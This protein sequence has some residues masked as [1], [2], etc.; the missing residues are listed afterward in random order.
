[1]DESKNRQIEPLRSL[2]ILVGIVTLVAFAYAMKEVLASV[3]IAIVLFYILDPMVHWLEQR[4]IGRWKISRLAA[5]LLVI[6]FVTLALTGMIFALIPPI[7]DQVERFS[8]NIPEYIKHIESTA[9]AL[10]QKYKRMELPLEVRA[11]LKNSF[12]RITAESM[13][14]IRQAAEKSAVLF[15]QIILLFM[16]PFIT[17]YLLLEKNDVKNALV[18][19]FPK[20][21]QNEIAVVVTESSRALHGYITGQLILSLLMGIAMTLALSFMGVKAPLL[22]GMKQ[23]D[24]S[25]VSFKIRHHEPSCDSAHHHGR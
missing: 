23:S 25:P 9:D 7:T 4:R 15:S 19:I 10:Q 2:I 21:L 18:S 14:L 24:S 3:T 6:L 22:L 16:M 5:V 12:E 11:S 13:G 20:K 1:M 17:F 8:K